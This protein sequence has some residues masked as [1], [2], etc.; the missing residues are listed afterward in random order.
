[1]SARRV[2]YPVRHPA[3]S[4]TLPASSSALLT[5]SDGR[6]FDAWR[7]GASAPRGRIL[8]C[9]GFWANRDQ[10][11][12]VA[13]GLRQR[14]Y[15]TV[16]FELRGHG[17]RPGPCTLG[18][19]ESED[20]ER[21]IRW[22]AEQDASPVPLGAVGFSMG[23]SVVCQLAS[24]MPTLRA[25]VADSLYSRFLPILARVIRQQYRLPSVP[26]AWLTWCSVQLALGRRVDRVDPAVLAPRL[27]Q[28]LL[29]IHCG[30]DRR[31]PIADGQEY[32]QR[33]AGPVERW[34]EPGLGHVGLFAQNPQAY[35]DRLAAFFDHALRP[36][37]TVN[38]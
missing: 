29:A 13:E 10:V 25:I 24:R 27:H 17:D 11:I 12:G 19:R 37:R 21:V 33:W 8:V 3:S 23:A 18:L 28:P 38:A 26:F 4:S 35:C 14:G 20:A 7:L 34:V 22:A 15:E 16:L 32:V 6:R 30:A 1:M 36:D 5:A 31:V 2:L 9:H